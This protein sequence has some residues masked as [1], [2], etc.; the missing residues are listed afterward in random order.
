MTIHLSAELERL[1]LDQVLAGHYHSQD[2]VIRE[3]PEQ[4]RKHSPTPTNGPG[5]TEA[6]FKQDLL[7]SG[8]ISSLPEPAE[9]ASR[10]VFQP[11]TLEGEPLSE[12][13]MRERR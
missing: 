10:P 9:P 3:A 1:V 7:K 2:D 6:E 13:I 11:I 8:R 4:L 12:T 5:M